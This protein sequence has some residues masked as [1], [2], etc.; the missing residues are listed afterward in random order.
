MRRIVSKPSAGLV[1]EAAHAL[2]NGEEPRIALLPV[3]VPQ[4]VLPLAHPRSA[5]SL[6]LKLLVDWGSLRT[7]L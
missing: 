2:D 7:G 1:H 3:L 6:G 4:L 5:G